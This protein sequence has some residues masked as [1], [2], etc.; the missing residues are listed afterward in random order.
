M[1]A[2]G[3]AG[4]PLSAGIQW[5]VP[6]ARPRMASR[7]PGCAP[8]AVGEREDQGHR[9]A[10]LDAD[11]GDHEKGEGRQRELDPVEA[12]NGPQFTR[13]EELGGDE[14]QHCGQHRL[15]QVGERPGERQHHGQD[16]GRGDG[17]GE[18]RA[19]TGRGRDRRVGRA[20]VD[21]ERPDQPGGHAACP[22]A[23]Q[24]PVD[25]ARCAGTPA[26]RPPDRGCGLR[27]AHEGH[28][29]YQAG[30]A[31]ELRPG[32]R[33]QADVRQPAVD[34]TE[35]RYAV[36]GCQAERADCHDGQDQREQRPREPAADA[37]GGGDD[38]QDA[39]GDAD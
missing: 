15:R 21:R 9:E 4:M 25:G 38:R 17:I 20:G 30:H 26:A 31:A 34:G 33:R 28:G 2:T 23:D 36:V 5:S 29:K 37:L 10:L 13:P 14:Y 7:G 6:V 12:E 3:W 8:G 11:H 32:D 18:L 35:D 16:D 27:D 19:G 22:D 24:V 39:D 1:P